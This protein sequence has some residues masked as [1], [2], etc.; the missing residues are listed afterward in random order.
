MTQCKLCKGEFSVITN[1]HLKTAH[2]ITLKNYTS[3]FGNSGTGFL[4]NVINL[5]RDDRRY[6]K[7]RKSL[8]GRE[9]LNWSRGLTKH[10]N[11]S[12]AKISRTFKRKKI[13]NFARWRSAAREKGIIPK[14]YPPLKKNSNLAFL[15]GLTLG[16]GNVHRFRRTE[17]IRITLG[18]DKPTLWKY[19][20]IIVGKV[21]KK[22]PTVR[23]VGSS[24]CVT[25]TLYQ[26]LISERLDIPPGNRAKLYVVVP[27][28]ILAKK[29]Y[30]VRYLRG[31]YEA[32]G[33]FCVHR[34]TGTYKFLFCNKNNSMI[35]NVW[36][37]M[38]SLGFHPHISSH[39]VQ[40]SR[41]S[42]VYEA[43]KVLG[44]RKYQTSS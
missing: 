42:E 32:E 27:K 9:N 4:V 21:F 19:A 28:W 18:T 41:K 38:T 17:S 2:Q 25:I 26:N 23:K 5:P 44:L 20:A 24:N 43:M 37:L 39:K 16:D 36:K 13:D 34:P 7:W 14:S 30:V 10:T 11:H 6:I 31:L 3:R 8:F 29:E 33:S 12:V 40:I 22:K 15:I 35:H 1:T